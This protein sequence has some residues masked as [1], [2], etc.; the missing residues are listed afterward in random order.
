MKRTIVLLVALLLASALPASPQATDN[1]TLLLQRVTNQ[2]GPG[3][4][5]VFIGKLPT[6]MPNVPLPGVSVLGS[7][8][9]K[10]QAKIPASPM[11]CITMRRRR[12]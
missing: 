3:K 4:G 5:Q 6:D 9:R 11:S 10:T 7:I 12:R 1:A 8:H 2:Y